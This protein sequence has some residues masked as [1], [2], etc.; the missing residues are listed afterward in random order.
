MFA[1]FAWQAELNHTGPYIE[2][3]MMSQEAEAVRL[4]QLHGARL[5]ADLIRLLAIDA[6]GEKSH[7]AEPQLHIQSSCHHHISYIVRC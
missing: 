6:Y 1:S 7:A 4:T 2:P 3:S 5:V